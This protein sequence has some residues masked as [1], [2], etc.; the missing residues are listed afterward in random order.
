[1][2][3][4]HITGHVAKRISGKNYILLVSRRNVELV[5]KCFVFQISHF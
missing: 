1:M 4:I 2:E 3:H 5:K